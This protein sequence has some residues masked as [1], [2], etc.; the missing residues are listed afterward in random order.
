MSHLES[1]HI[2]LSTPKREET[3][4]LIYTIISLCYVNFRQKSFKSTLTYRQPQ[5]FE[6]IQFMTSD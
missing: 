4:T 3:R 1:Y 2:C 6:E 5:G